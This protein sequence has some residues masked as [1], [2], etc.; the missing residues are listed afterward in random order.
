MCREHIAFF[1]NYQLTFNFK[2]TYDYLTI[3]RRYHLSMNDIGT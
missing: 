1:F 3:Y 2:Y